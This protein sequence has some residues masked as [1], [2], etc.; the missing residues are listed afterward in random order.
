M[1]NHDYTKWTNLFI[2][3]QLM[4]IIKSILLI[5]KIQQ[6]NNILQFPV[7]PC[8]VISET[9]FIKVSNTDL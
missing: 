9:I 6:D 1:P 7:K 8:T 4:Y 3:F 2:A 5:A